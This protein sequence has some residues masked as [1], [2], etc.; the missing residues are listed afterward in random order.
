VQ[1]TT[2]PWGYRYEGLP[3]AGAHRQGVCLQGL[4]FT[5]S[6]KGVHIFQWKTSSSGRRIHMLDGYLE[7]LQAATCCV[8]ATHVRSMCCW[9]QNIR[10]WC[11]LAV[12]DLHTR[13][14]YL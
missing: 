14:D 6:F 10:A 4:R 13:V 2:A 3:E 5:M 7:L 9:R 8:P 12:W 11:M 1:R